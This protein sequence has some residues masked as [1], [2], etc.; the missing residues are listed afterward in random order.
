MVM[1]ID[2][3]MI[4]K[5]KSA[6]PRASAQTIRGV[7]SSIIDDVRLRGDE[8]VLAYAAQ[9]DGAQRARFRVGNDEIAAA[10]TQVSEE[11]LAAMRLALNNIRAF[12]EVQRASLGEVDGFEVMP[13]LMLGHKLVP[14]D[15]VCC[16]VPGG[17][18]PLFSTAL[19]LVTPAKAAGVRRIAAC[20]PVM[21][22]S[23]SINPKTL[24]ALSLA[25]ATE[26]YALGGAQAIAAF[27]YGT[28]QIQ[29]VDMIVGPG[30]AYV[31]ESKRQCYGQVGIDFVAGPSEV[32]II[33]D[34]S[35]DPAIV[36]AD[37]LAQCEHDK[38]A[39][40]ILV[41]FSEALA[42][43]VLSQIETQL[44]ALSTVEIAAASW[45]MNGE[46]L[47]AESID[48]AAD[49]VN[50]RA[51]EHLELQTK[52]NAALTPKLR[53]YG[54]L[55]IGKYSAEVFGDYAAGTNHTLPT[56][57]AARYTGGLWVGTFLKT[58]TYQHAGAAAAA[59]LAPP[60]SLLAA[61]EGL[62][63]HSAAACRRK[64]GFMPRL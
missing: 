45:E 35:A 59:A 5:I 41:S 63:A 17:S 46:V 43:Q 54:A 47:L 62:A 52:D 48:E 25:G 4:K 53:N 56:A 18:Y 64:G 32:L 57:G 26:I 27:A 49:W 23:G 9:F 12:A 13:G 2:S 28:D 14:V 16:Y 7:V 36:A 8:A 29:R 11:E 55:F 39:Q 6:K 33:A 44:P 34:E 31:A 58:L 1:S 42:E 61:A 30:N 40:S 21:K 24:A 50:Q 38:N 60:V 22:G 20:S 19:M 3:K 37:L 10:F 15:A 51:P